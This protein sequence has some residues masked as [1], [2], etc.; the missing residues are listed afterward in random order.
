MI[1]AWALG[2]A[3]LGRDLRWELVSG[4][5]KT[6]ACRNFVGLSRISGG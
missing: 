1:A 4:C 5:D 2:F 3:L 6:G